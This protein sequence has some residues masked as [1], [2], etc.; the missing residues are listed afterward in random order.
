MKAVSNMTPLRY[1]IA[2]EREHLL[3]QIFEKVFIPDT[4]H[5]ELTDARTPEVVRRCLASPPPWLEVRHVNDTIK[6]QFPFSLHRGEAEAILLVEE[7]SA[8]LLLVDE[9]VGRAIAHSRN[10]P[11]SGTLGVLERAD[12][13]GLLSDFP[14][15]LVQLRG[16]GF[17][18]ADALEKQLMDRHIRR[19]MQ[20][21]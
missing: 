19:K 17:F 11:V 2:I 3:G 18:I 14:N 13:M 12:A 4:V 16:S 7:L 5:A 9:Q 1:L 10:L 21:P 20:K 8:D 15:V 6:P